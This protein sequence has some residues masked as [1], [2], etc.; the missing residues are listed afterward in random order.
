MMTAR[1]LRSTFGLALHLAR[2]GSS[3]T[4]VASLATTA[5]LATSVVGCAD[6]NDPATWVKRL[7]DAAQR[8]AAIKRISEFFNDTLAKANQNRDAPEVKALLDKIAEPMTKQYTGTALDDKTRKELIK[9]LAD[10]RDIRTAPALAKAFNEYDPGKN[11]E[12]VKYAA[13]AVG[14][15]AA[16]GKLTDQSLT[17]S[18]WNVF[19]KFQVSKAKSINL[20]KDLHDA[21]LAAANPSYGP[22]AVEKLSASFDAKNEDA[23]KDHLQFWQ[24]TAVQVLGETKFAGGVKPL[25]RVL[26]NKDK[27]GLRPAVTAAL[28]KMPVESEAALIDALQGNDPEVQKDAPLWG[29]DKLHMG[30]L[31]DA[32]AWISRPKGKDAIISA[33]AAAPSDAARTLLAQP[34]IRYSGD[35]KVV[36]AYTDAYKKL[37]PGVKI[38]LLGNLFARPALAQAAASLYDPS[39]VDWLVKDAVGAKGDEAMSMQALALES[40]IKLMNSSQTKTVGDAVKKLWSTKE[41]EVFT[42]AAKVVDECGAKADCYVKVLDEPVTGSAIAMMRPIKAAQMCAQMGDASTK[43]ALVTKIDKMKDPGVRLAAVQAIDH[44]S[45]KGDP[46]AAEVLEKIVKGDQGKAGG[47]AND[48]LAKVALRL[49]ARALP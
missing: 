6:E 38:E 32:I 4:S 41:Q 24:L 30:I 12:D 42:T 11:D 35:P 28:M 36:T 22:K 16:G 37:A 1:K 34:L 25:V 29:A 49:R 10:T 43:Q 23:A 5:L 3:G 33:L 15:L 9:F 39:L 44:L 13:Q 14:A 18:L 27:Q 19:A 7:D 31:A 26:V 48:A 21:V 40:A 17:D 8:P 46:A 45:P 20:V 47:A 2:L